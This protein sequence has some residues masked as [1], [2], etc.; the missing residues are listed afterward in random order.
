MLSL[1]IVQPNLQLWIYQKKCWLAKER[2]VY[3][4][5]HQSNLE[6]SQVFSHSTNF[7]AIIAAGV[8]A[9]AHAGVEVLNNLF[10]LL[11]EEGLL[12]LTGHDWRI[13]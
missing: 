10:G 11:K 2:Q 9:Y 5:L 6:D 7:D 3:K 13:C 4:A 12:L 1:T 8:F